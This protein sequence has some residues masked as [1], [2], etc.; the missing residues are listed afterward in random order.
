[1]TSTTRPA[2]FMPPGGKLAAVLVERHARVA[3]QPA[4]GA[5]ARL[6]GQRLLGD[7][8]LVDDHQPLAH[9][10]VVALADDAFAAALEH[11]RRAGVGRPRRR[12]GDQRGRDRRERQRRPAKPDGPKHGGKNSPPSCVPP[13]R[14]APL[15]AL[16]AFVAE[17][18][19]RPMA[20]S[21]LFFRIKAGQEILAR[22][23]LPGRNLFSFTYPDHP[24][25]DAAWLFEVGAA[26]LSR[27]RRVSRR[28]CVAKTA[29]LLAAF[30][31]GVRAL[32]AARRRGRP[33]A[34]WRS[35][36]AAF[37]GRERF[38]ERPHVFSL[39][40]VVGAAVRDRRAGRASGQAGARASAAG[41]C[42][43]AWR[44]GPT[45]TRASSWRP[46]CWPAPPRARGSTAIAA[47]RR[48]GSGWRR[49]RAA[50]RAVR[51]ADRLRPA[52]L[53]APAPDAA[54]AAPG[55]R[56]SRARAGCPI[57]RCSSTR[58]A[59]VAGGRARSAGA[60][61]A[62]DRGAARAGVRG[63]WRRVRSA[64]A[65]TSRWRRRRCW[66]WR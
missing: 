15:V 2:S 42:A 11:E 16:L 27:A 28:S 51:H 35:A 12:A 50:A 24:D 63:C 45:C 55:R 46:C 10:P 29:V 65:P 39:L 21:D 53:P 66:R 58:A 49:W 52:P 56:V 9:V 20:E 7:A 59:L 13:L 19:L 43:P 64:S 40:G 37:A 14:V 60:A 23:G 26:A 31:A 48:A 47:A 41:D 18:S 1:M 57:R 25:L 61:S 36:A 32:P 8:A 54:G 22:H 3:R 33:P 17:L 5:I 44:C 62:L 6:R 34:R 4:G 38:V 30:A